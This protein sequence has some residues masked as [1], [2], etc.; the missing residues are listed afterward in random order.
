MRTLRP[1]LIALFLLLTHEGFATG[2]LT[3][4]AGTD[5]MNLF[6]FEL[7]SRVNGLGGAYCAAAEDVTGLTSNPA[8]L[9]PL[10]RHQA[11]FVH[12]DWFEDTAVEYLAYAQPL[13]IGSLR[14]T[15]GG[16]WTFLHVTPFANYDRNGYLDGTVRFG[17]SVVNLAYATRIK[18]YSLGMQ[19]KWGTLGINETRLNAFAADLGTQFFIKNI[20]F[21]YFP[22]K[23]LSLNN[24]KVGIALQNI[25]TK[26]GDDT[27]PLKLKA[28]LYYPILIATEGSANQSH[29]LYATL[30]LNKYL[31]HIRSVIDLDYRFNAGLEYVFRDLVF[32]RCGF[33]LGYDLNFF[34]AGI[35]IRYR[36]KGFDTHVDYVYS[37]YFVF[38]SVNNFSVNTKFDLFDSI[39]GLNPNQQKLMELY[40]Y[41]GLS[42][43]VQ[44]E[45]EK[46]IQEWKKA[47][48][49]DP[50]N[51]VIQKKI[52]EAEEIINSIKK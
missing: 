4:F 17:S 43:F 49:I 35:G 6:Q 31:Y 46:A 18:Q 23:W 14:G 7:N 50:E 48:A 34:T 29:S 36:F 26:A 51:K 44:E 24:V 47:L 15:I 27:V 12:L 45:F 10:N 42:Y 39:G 30:D 37:P 41:K 1:L 2:R 28:G 11:A 52:K 25:S 8:G 3:D 9:V 13:R 19:L 32:V 20:K 38:N 33:K 16:S 40:Y 22:G 5:G 21:P